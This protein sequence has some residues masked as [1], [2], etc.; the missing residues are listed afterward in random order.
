VFKLS[1]RTRH[2]TTKTTKPVWQCMNAIKHGIDNCPH[3]KAIDEIMIE[4]A[5]LESFRLLTENFDDVLESVLNT[6]E[7]V[8]KDDT[9]LKRVK[10][11]EKE[12]SS[13]KKKKSR[14]TDLLVDGRIEQED[15]DEK[16]G[17]FQRKIHKLT[18]EKACLE[19]NIGQQKS[20]WH[21]SGRHSK[22]KIPWINLTEWYLKALWRKSLLADMM[23]ME[24]RLHINW[25]SY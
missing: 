3:C 6:V 25:L 9:E 8:L 7:E 20:V 19:S 2:Q 24:I 17:I 13:I 14:L 21:S 5:F 1:R 15:Y 23:Q 22:M 12:I 11:L 16:K 10:K 4:E 18:E